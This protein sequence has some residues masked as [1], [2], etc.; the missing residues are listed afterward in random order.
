MDSAGNNKETADYDDKAEVINRCMKNPRGISADQEIMATDDGSE[1]ETEPM[2]VPFPVMSR[3]HRTEC[4]GEQKNSERQ[5]DQLVR[6]RDYRHQSHA[7]IGMG[8]ARFVNR[9]RS[10]VSSLY[11]I[12][13]V[14]TARP[15]LGFILIAIFFAFGA[16]V[17]LITVLALAF[18]ESSLESIWR[19]KPEARV[20]FEQLGRAPA[21][22]LMVA[23]GLACGL[24]AIGLARNSD[25]GR[26]LGIGILAVNLVGDSLNALFRHDPKTLI[27]VPIGGLLIWYLLRA[28][29]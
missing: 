6:L 19:L 7:L 16:V 27:G 28:K 15:S 3:D 13:L 20:Q 11:D 4:D 26:K 24:A 14:K 5:H 23:V 8:A 1:A 12:D 2:V 25:W 22:A 21:I 29:R 9:T 10:D 17:C 18:P